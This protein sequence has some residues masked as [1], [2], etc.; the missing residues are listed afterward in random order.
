MSTTEDLVKYAQAYLDPRIPA[1]EDGA[2]AL[3]LPENARWQADRVR[4]RL[5][6]GEGRAGH[7]VISH[8][9]GSVGATANLLI[10]PEQHLIVALLTNTD[11]PFVGI[12]WKLANE[13][14][15]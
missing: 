5:G 7:T 12:A 3:D 14:L 6:R 9:G 8:S 4:H 11:Q 13:F 2:A 15:E 10:Y 1:A